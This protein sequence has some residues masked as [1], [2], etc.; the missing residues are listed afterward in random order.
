MS[1]FS[2]EPVKEE[3]MAYNYEELAF[4]EFPREAHWSGPRPADKLETYKA[5]IIGGGIAGI[6]A[7]V[8]FQ[9]LGIPFIVIER[10]HDIGGTW[11]LNT[12]PGARVDTSSYLFQKYLNF[13]A[14]KHNIRESF[15]FNREV[16]SAVWNER[17]GVWEIAMQHKDGKTETIRANAIVSACGL[18]STPKLPDIPGIETFKK[19]MFHT[20]QWDHSAE[21]AGK[22]VALIGTG[23]TGT[24][25]APFVAK[26]AASLTV[27]QR[28]PN[29]SMALQGYRDPLDDKVRYLFDKIPYY[30]NW[31]CYGQ[32][33]AAQQ[34]QWLQTYDR[35][36]QKNGGQ[37]NER[38]DKVRISL[39]EYAKE[40]AA[41]VPG[42]LNKI[43]PKYTPLV[44]RLVVDDGFYDML[45]HDHVEL[46]T[47]GIKDI[48]ANGI[49][50]NDGVQHDLD[51]LI[52]GAGFHTSAYF[53]PVKYVGRNGAT[54]A[55]AWKNDGARSYLGL[56]NP[57]MPN[58]FSMYGPNHAPRSGGYYSW[59]EIWARYT[60]SCLVHL[61]ENDKTSLEPRQDLY[62]SY[63]ADL[64]EAV[65]DLIWEEEGKSYYCNEFGRS[66]VNMPW[67]T[68]EYHKMVAEPNF[69]DFVIQ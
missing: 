17:L 45:S 53:H 4:D 28:T 14:T 56:T 55:E 69:A 67:T 49:L 57:G 6:A 66:A 30:W 60:A 43:L 51:L 13:I 46:V 58:F 9:R 38:N 52:L 40:K 42:L 3:D 5:V 22:R 48:N 54:F 16:L 68:A 50:D 34:L 61:I 8:Q 19:P 65:K 32:H 35:E 26:A 63:N 7:A 18:F 10:Q 12:Y 37:V 33:V 11:L 21:Y 31:Y 59:A 36:W 44:R 25:L 15:L 1:L 20:A 41:N 47:S 27:F 64:D 29:W 39:T 24:Q 62:D 23:S 2:G